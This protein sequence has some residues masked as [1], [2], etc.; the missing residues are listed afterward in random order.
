[1]HDINVILADYPGLG[2]VRMCE[3]NAIHVSI[4][5]VTLNL[6]PDAFLQMTALMNR[7]SAQLSKI[8]EPLESAECALS[9]FKM[10]QS[11]FTN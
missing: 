1:M 8:K 11:R 9:I 10:P 5:P 6:E 3:C 4:G 7:A 2:R